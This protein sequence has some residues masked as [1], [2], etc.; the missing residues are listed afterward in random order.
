MDG[1]RLK[2]APRLYALLP[3]PALLFTVFGVRIFSPPPGTGPLRPIQ[4]IPLRGVSGRLDHMAIDVPRQRLFVAALASNSILVINLRT[5]QVTQTLRGFHEPQ[6]VCFVA[7]TNRL[8][9]TNGGDGTC[10]VLDGSSYRTV[11]TARLGSDADNAH[12]EADANQ[13]Y[14]GYGSGALGVLDAVTGKALRSISLPEHP[15]GFQLDLSGPRIYVNLPRV[16]EVAVVDRDSRRVIESWPLEGKPG[17]F[18]LALDGMKRRLFVGCRHPAMVLIYDCA[19]GKRLASVPIHDDVDN[20]FF[21]GARR[22]LYAAC[23]AGYVDVLVP[24]GEQDYEP[25]A[26]IA[27]APGARTALFAPV[28]SRLYVALPRSGNRGAEIR[29]FQITP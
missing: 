7:Q 15:E 1:P 16:G 9:V 14:V 29:V 10:V 8:F 6:G 23:G 20:L 2:A 3:I 24:K 19:T 27:T 13:V 17:N 26:M 21:D 5:G 12:Y 25:S 22:R 4:S 11:G 28:L 18:P